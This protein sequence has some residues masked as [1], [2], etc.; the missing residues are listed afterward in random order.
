MA[1]FCR[2]VIGASRQLASSFCCC[3]SDLLHSIPAAAEMLLL[4]LEQVLPPLSQ[5]QHPL[6]QQQ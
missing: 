5:L 6:Q 2:G 1:C 3:C 4:P